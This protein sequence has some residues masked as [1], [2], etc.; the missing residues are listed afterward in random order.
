MAGLI[1]ENPNAIC[2]RVGR[3]IFQLRISWL[4]SDQIAPGKEAKRFT[5]PLIV[6]RVPLPAW[7]GHVPVPSHPWHLARG[8]KFHRA[9]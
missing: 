8:A 3:Q 1:I 2:I 6:R 9:E 7:A 5:S 4:N